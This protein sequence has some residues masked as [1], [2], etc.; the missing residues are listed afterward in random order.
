[1]FSVVISSRRGCFLHLSLP[2]TFEG[3]AAAGL[4]PL[5]RHFRGASSQSSFSPSNACILNGWGIGSIW[6]LSWV[7]IWCKDSYCLYKSKSW[8]SPTGIPKKR[9]C[10][11]WRTNKWWWWASMATRSKKKDK[12]LNISPL[13]FWSGL[14]DERKIFTLLITKEFQEAELL[15]YGV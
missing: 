3:S 9:R 2:L 1:M 12:E 8:S 11:R 6:T 10:A 4:F 13:S 14:L 15:K 5:S 7:T